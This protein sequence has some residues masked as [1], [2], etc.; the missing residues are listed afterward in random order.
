MDHIAE[1]RLCGKLSLWTGTVASFSSRRYEDTRSQKSPWIKNEKSKEHS[2]VGCE[3]SEIKVRSHTSREEGWK[4]VHFANL[5]DL[6]H[7]KNAE[8][9]TH[10]QKYWSEFCSGKDNV[11]DAERCR[12]EFTE[13]GASA[14]Q[15]A[16]AKFL[17]TILTLPGMAGETSDAIS[18]YTQVKMTEAPIV[19]IVEG[20]VS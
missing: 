12:A 1:K 17:D 19:T 6:C 4:K 5:M 2:S 7:L 20:G 3:E 15:M 10:L 13:Q 16:A 9:A 18:A 11:K 14:S 8:L